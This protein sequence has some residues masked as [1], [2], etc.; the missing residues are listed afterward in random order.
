MKR[1]IFSSIYIFVVLQS[2]FVFAGPSINLSD[3]SEIKVFDDNSHLIYNTKDE[4][5]IKRFATAIKKGD[6]YGSNT[7]YLNLTQEIHLFSSEVKSSKWYVDLKLGYYAALTPPKLA[8]YRFK[9]D[10]FNFIQKTI[11][12]AKQSLTPNGNSATPR[13][14]E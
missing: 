3:I 8:I 11:I 13:S 12:N 10:D 1:N 6:W 9:K 5:L 14:H 7:Y 4:I 2:G